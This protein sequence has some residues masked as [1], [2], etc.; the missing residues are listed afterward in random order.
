MKRWLA[1][2]LLAAAL[3]PASAVA[4]V[5]DVNASDARKA[6]QDG[7]WA[8][9]I[10]DWNELYLKG[11]REGSGQLCGLYF[12]GRRGAFDTAEGIDWC[13]RAAADGDAWARYRMGLLYLVGVGVD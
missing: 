12:D 8:Q 11:E 2:A 4:A 5:R 9:A 7:N 6:V 13:R 3:I 10:A 1:A